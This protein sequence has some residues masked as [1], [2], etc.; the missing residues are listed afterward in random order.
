MPDRI[1]IDVTSLD[2]GDSIHIGDIDLGDKVKLLAD[3]GLTVAAVVAPIVE[4]EEVPE[5]EL[6]EAEEAPAEEAEAAGESPD[7]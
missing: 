6:E 5:E 2:I 1:E 4:E 7:K 3:T